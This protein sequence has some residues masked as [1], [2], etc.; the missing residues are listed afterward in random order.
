[1][2]DFERWLQSQLHTI[3]APIWIDKKTC[4]LAKRFPRLHWTWSR[5]R[6]FSCFTPFICFL[7]HEHAFLKRRSG[8]VLV[9]FHSNIHQPCVCVS[10]E[11][12]VLFND[13]FASVIVIHKSMLAH[14]E[15]PQGGSAF[16]QSPDEI[17]A[18][19]DKGE[20]YL[21]HGLCVKMNSS[22]SPNTKHDKSLK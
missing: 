6:I 10:S 1:M 8:G 17:R 7:Q 16:R 21:A 13:A 9:P 18:I 12:Q 15:D 3:S 11:L 20:K 14:H 2:H 22:H 19:V 4:I 5:I